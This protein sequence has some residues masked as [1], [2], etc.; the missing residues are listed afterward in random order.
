MST[1][2][3]A[4]ETAYW[5]QRAARYGLRGR[6]LAAVCSY[7]MPEYHN[8]AI[9]AVQHLALRRWLDVLAARGRVL[10]VGCGV[11]RWSR[12]LAAR[13]AR[14]TGV[15][16]ASTMVEEARR[17]TRSAGLDAHCD[18]RVG[19]VA[20]LDLGERFDGILAVT[21][22]QHVLDPEAWRVALRALR[23]HLC[24][25][26]RMVLLEAA[27]TARSTRCDTVVFQARTADAY[28][29]A[30]REAGLRCTSMAG[31]DPAPFRTWFLPHYRALPAVVRQAGLAA[32]TAASLPIDLLAGRRAVSAS[33][34]KV[35]VLEAEA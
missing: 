25:D 16:L 26:G 7:G 23:A 31:V 2:L 8:L 20:R 33:W 5:E 21:V 28:L 32:V 18:F 13:G 27:P 14:V 30:F 9:D 19:D 15:D 12:R 34:H 17:R 3:L 35:F 4:S 29:A 11:G 22:L 10:D 6:G 1:T 24:P